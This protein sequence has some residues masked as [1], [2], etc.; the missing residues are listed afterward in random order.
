[1]KTIQ[2]A[3]LLDYF[4]LMLLSAIWGSAFVGIGYALSAF[5]PV[6]VA[7]YRI[8]I[9]AV[10]IGL[11]VWIKHL[12]LPR[13]RRSWTLLGVLGLVNNALPFYLI[14]WGQQYVSASTAAVILAIGPFVALLMAHWL[15][16]DEKITPFKLVG[17]ALGFA[18]VF[19]L[20]G[21][22]FFT[23]ELN[24]LYGKLAILIAT[25]GYVSSGLMIRRLSH[26]DTLVCAGAM[27]ATAVLWMLPF[28]WMVPF[29]QSTIL[30]APFLTILYLALIPTALASIIRI[31]LVQRTG[32]Q[33][34]S[35]VSYLIPLFAIFWTWVF[36]GEV[37]E[38]I[39]WVALGL[40]LSGLFIRKLKV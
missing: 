26:I 10:A 16:H 31:Q 11:F 37:P 18:G 8:L 20:F 17:V 13:D 32:V 39:V 12:P 33:F 4:W 5:P 7:F 38:F 40:I 24:S 22:D 21:E 36:L 35:Q 15:T 34:M 23:G 14:S 19:I 3:T 28:V 29:G 9:A 1:M 2:N 30:S 6:I 27:F 25:I